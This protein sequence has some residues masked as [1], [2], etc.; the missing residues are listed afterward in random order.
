[1]YGRNASKAYIDKNGDNIM[2]YVML[3]GEGDNTEAIQRT[4]YSISTIEK[5]GIKNQQ[6]ALQICNWRENLAMLQN[7]YLKNIR[8]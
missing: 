8:N 1:M 7:Y 5:A 3:E 6:V 2:Q 4:K